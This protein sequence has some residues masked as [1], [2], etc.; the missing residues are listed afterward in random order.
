MKIRY[1]IDFEDMA[2]YGKFFLSNSPFAVKWR[3]RLSIICAVF[4]FCGFS[5]I[6]ISMGEPVWI[7]YGLVFQVIFVFLYLRYSPNAFAM[8]ST[9]R[10]NGVYSQWLKASVLG[11]NEL[12]LLSDAMQKT[13]SG[14]RQMTKYTRINHVE[15]IGTHVFVFNDYPIPNIIPKNKISEGDLDAFVVALKQKL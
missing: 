5:A 14:K 9:H 12:E 13:R 15:D 4:S 1:I 6:V 7:L 11:G 3:Q 8:L 2:A 10:I